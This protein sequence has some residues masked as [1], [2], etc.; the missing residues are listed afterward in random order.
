MS[1]KRARRQ[2]GA[3]IVLFAICIV[4]LVCIIA[5]VVDIGRLYA[6]K[7]RAQNVADATVIGG[8]W[9]LDGTA[10][11]EGPA[12]TEVDALAAA[13]NQRTGYWKVIRLTDDLEGVTSM[14]LPEGAIVPL[15]DGSTTTVGPYRAVQVQC[16]VKVEFVF[17]PIMDYFVSR[18]SATAIAMWK[19]V[20]TLRYPCVPWAVPKSAIPTDPLAHPEMTLKVTS[21]K[22]PDAFIGPG[23][24]LALDYGSGAATYRD[25]VDGYPRGE[26]VPPMYLTVGGPVSPETG[27]IIGPTD[28]GLSRRLAR[29]TVFPS[30][31]QDLTAFQDW[32][33]AGA[34]DGTYE[35]TCLL[36]TSPSPRDRS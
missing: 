18:P 9:L 35:L 29:D 16:R 3:T 6:A 14:V 4:A 36:Y 20:S 17:A 15:G 25:Y 30:P 23:N 21:H 24:F 28:Q 2:R 10:S 33:T 11:S 13:N 8:A 31:E 26:P 22:D 27:N 12:L 34:Q 7:Q 19:S 1:P 32:R 5:L